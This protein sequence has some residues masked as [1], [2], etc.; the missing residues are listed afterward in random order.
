MGQALG[1]GV[2]F[3]V[4]VGEMIAA[5]I[6]AESEGVV[7]FLAD[8]ILGFDAVSLCHIQ[9]DAAFPQVVGKGKGLDGMGLEDFDDG[10]CGDCL[11]YGFL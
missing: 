9:G 7:G 3:V 11:D 1:L 10:G 6:V 8:H 5:G 4:T 2:V